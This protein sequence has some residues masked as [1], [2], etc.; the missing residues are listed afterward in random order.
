MPKYIDKQCWDYLLNLFH[1]QLQL[2]SDNFHITGI[3]SSLSSLTLML[4][5]LF[6]SYLKIFGQS[7]MLKIDEKVICIMEENLMEVEAVCTAFTLN[8]LLERKHLEMEVLQ[9][10]QLNTNLEKIK[11]I[12]KQ[13]LSVSSV[14]GNNLISVNEKEQKY[15]EFFLRLHVFPSNK[16]MKIC[17]EEK[18]DANDKSENENNDNVPLNK[19]RCLRENDNLPIEDLESEKQSML[20]LQQM[21]ELSKKLLFISHKNINKNSKMHGMV[22]IVQDNLRRY[23]Q[24]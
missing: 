7:T 23:L 20:I 24:N 8:Y 22:Q 14:K 18:T 4:R 13:R 17:S 6:N 11:F 2:L 16:V 21:Q 3:K 5:S 1:L 19:K 10:L 12:L 9:K 15:M